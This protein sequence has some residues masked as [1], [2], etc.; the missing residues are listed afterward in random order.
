MP[1]YVYH[2]NKC[3]ETFER[4]EGMGEHG[5]KKPRCPACKS[6]RVGQRLTPVTVKTSRKS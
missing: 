3:G 5:R 4:S 1:T 6:T 2:C